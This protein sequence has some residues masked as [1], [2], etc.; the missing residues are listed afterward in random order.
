LPANIEPASLPTPS[1]TLFSLTAK[2]R[3][4]ARTRRALRRA[5]D[6]SPTQPGHQRAARNM[7][8]YPV[9]ASLGPLVDRALMEA[10]KANSSINVR[11]PRFFPPH[12]FY[13]ESR[14]APTPK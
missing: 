3:S 1:A 7:Q 12:F 4:Y 9:R 2:R 10:K 5:S 8:R 6:T 13:S 14:R 11:F